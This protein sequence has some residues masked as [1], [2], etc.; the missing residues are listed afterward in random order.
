MPN[1][2]VIRPLTGIVKLPCHGVA[3]LFRPR[4]VA[5]SRRITALICLDAANSAAS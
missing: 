1:G 2:D 5:C 4:G 3:M